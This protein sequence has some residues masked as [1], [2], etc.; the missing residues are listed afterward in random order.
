MANVHLLKSPAGQAA[1]SSPGNIEQFAESIGIDFNDIAGDGQPLDQLDI[2]F[3]EVAEFFNV[4]S[5]FPSSKNGAAVRRS[6]RLQGLGL[7]PQGAGT[8]GRSASAKKQR[9]FRF[10]FSPSNAS[11]SSKA[12][13]FVS[14]VQLQ[15]Q[16]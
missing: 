11:E 9:V 1:L 4:P 5:P 6:P 8:G 16:L 2:D 3:N 7:T 13:D 12:F 15:L 10:D 14:T